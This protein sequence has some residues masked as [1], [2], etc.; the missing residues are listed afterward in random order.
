MR[1]RI[2]AVARKEFIHIVREPR[3]MVLV[4]LM[5][6][7]QLVLFGY[8][9][10]FDIKDIPLLVVDH[11]RSPES[12]E[13]VR[14]FVNSTRFTVVGYPRSAEDGI[15]VLE[16]GKARCMLV[17]PRDFHE[18][19]TRGQPQAIQLVIDGSDP[20]VGRVALA[21]AQAIAQIR[22]LRAV[23]AYAARHGSTV[24][25]E[26]PIA[27]SARV[28]FNPEFKSV[29][30]IVPG[31]IAIFLIVLPTVLTASAIVRERETRTIEQL[32]VSPLKPGELLTGKVLPY[33][34]MAV[35]NAALIIVCGAVLFQVPVRGSLVALIALS[36]LYIISTVSMG[37]LISSIAN[38]VQVAVLV[39]M[40]STYLPSLLLSGF[41][42]PIQS[43]PKALQYL[44]YVFPTRYFVSGARAVFLK[45]ASLVQIGEELV[46]LAGLTALIVV[47]TLVR[48][49][50]F[51][52]EL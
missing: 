29:N 24:R 32:T 4:F 41:I 47:A 43:M 15:D 40:I 23:N 9:L 49:R 16:A 45:G 28:L 20:S 17:V 33:V 1:D 26:L 52:Y 39:A 3:T 12:R 10:S 50:R 11:D 19:A 38:S 25:M 36:V 5:P 18:R 2:L 31:L 22:S 42:F 27:I 46:W 7:L 30:F 37:L 13:L 35:V 48:L 51:A 14:A 44:S 6:L 34:G 21:F 8:A